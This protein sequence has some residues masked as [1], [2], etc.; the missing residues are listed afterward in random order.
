MLLALFATSCGKPREV[1]ARVGKEVNC[2]K[3]LG[4]FLKYLKEVRYPEENVCEIVK[5][6]WFKKNG[7]LYD[8]VLTIT[9][10]PTDLFM[11]Y[12]KINVYDTLEISYDYAKYKVNTTIYLYASEINE[13][14]KSG[15]TANYYI[16]VN[17][18]YITGSIV[19][20]LPTLM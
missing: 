20:N 17:D 2:E 11:N 10:E 9:S 5:S 1:K 18:K 16:I 6:G 7:V 15:L 8:N 19:S 13:K 4:N 14:E 12:M 3:E